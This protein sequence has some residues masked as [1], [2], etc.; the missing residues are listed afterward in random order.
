MSDVDLPAPPDGTPDAGPF[1]PW[2]AERRAPV[3]AAL[4][5]LLALPP[6]VPL[7]W[8]CTRAPVRSGIGVVVVQIPL[9]SGEPLAL[10]LGD[11]AL[12]ESAWLD[13]GELR[14]AYRAHTRGDAL[15]DAAVGP[16]LRALA[17]RLPAVA[18]RQPQLLSALVDALQAMR[19]LLGVEDWMFRQLSWSISG[20]PYGR[21][22]LGFRC[23]QNCD[24]CWQ[25]RRWGEPDARWYHV[26]LDELAAA[27][28]EEIHFTG[29]EPTLHAALPALVAR[30]A[31][32]HG[33]LVTLQTNAMRLAKPHVL[34][35]LVDAGAGLAFVSLHS[36]DPAV[37]DAITRA[38]GT[39]HKTVA[40]VEAA[41]RAGLVVTLNAVLERRNAAGVAELA[42]F[43][44][45]RFVRPFP[46]NPV[47]SLC[48][49]QP[50]TYYDETPWEDALVPL[51]ELAGPLR[52]AADV[53]GAAG[54]LCQAVGSCGYPPCVLPDHRDIHVAFDRDASD[55]VDQGSRR[56]GAVCAGCAARADCPGVRDEYLTAFGERGL[57][58]MQR[59]VQ[60]DAFATRLAAIT[61][62]ARA[63]V[64]ARASARS[65]S[66]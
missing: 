50:S 24:I 58:P 62:D 34:G 40:G 48:L 61:A 64:A 65:S 39:F 33:L 20:R 1:T 42:R 54:V 29:G 49:S 52:E 6:H 14:V 66:A 22:R 30:A 59:P 37:S 47:R 28:A 21:L 16:V 12:L 57:T 25:D 5:A 51:D 60:G 17:L 3:D 35:P 56:F 18:Q 32:D 26:W 41:L 38:P 53:L 43:V 19:Q 45:E 10:E 2:L 23:N 15:Q 8:L 44:V 11:P 13:L 31:R 63:R 27:G 9:A 7:A 55:A 4:R 36:A 46:D